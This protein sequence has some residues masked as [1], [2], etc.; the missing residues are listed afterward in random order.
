MDKVNIKGW[1]VLVLCLAG[2][3]LVLPYALWSGYRDS[4]NLE[5]RGKYQKGIV[6]NTKGLKGKTIIVRY[7]I[8]NQAF[9]KVL[10]APSRYN[11]REGDS[12]K[13]LYDTLDY[14]NIKP[15]W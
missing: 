8:N 10:T 1:I 4:K 14:E 5:E 2:V 15:V 3:F 13:I 7:Y 6:V 11:V 12:L 9:E